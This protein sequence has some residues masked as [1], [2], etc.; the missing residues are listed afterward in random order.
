[1]ETVIERP[2][3]R[4]AAGPVV[5]SIAATIAGLALA[6]GLTPDQSP[7]LPIEIGV[8]LLAIGGWVW[9][10]GSRPALG[11]ALVFGGLLTALTLHILVGDLQAATGPRELVPDVLVLASTLAVV[12][13]SAREL[14]GRR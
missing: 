14:V 9:L 13:G 6:A 4:R 3:H 8:V 12:A 5:A 2:T 1:M 10:R 7:V 11:T